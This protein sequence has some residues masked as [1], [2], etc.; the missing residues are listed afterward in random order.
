[1]KQLRTAPP[2][3]LTHTS[4]IDDCNFDEVESELAEFGSKIES[5]QGEFGS[6]KSL[7]QEEAAEHERLERQLNEI[8]AAL[9]NEVMDG[10]VKVKG[11]DP[12]GARDTTTEVTPEGVT[13]VVL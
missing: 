11:A 8:E 1:M 6:L 12:C 4:N 9:N 13:P 3:P 5:V 2:P 10:S 7:F